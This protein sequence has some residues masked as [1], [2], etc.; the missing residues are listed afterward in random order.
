M[1]L[2][3]M[4]RVP[5]ASFLPRNGNPS[6]KKL[7]DLS[8]SNLK[9][10]PEG[11]ELLNIYLQLR[12]KAWKPWS[13]V[14]LP[15]QKIQSVFFDGYHWSLPWNIACTLTGKKTLNKMLLQSWL[16]LTRNLCH[17][18]VHLPQEFILGCCQISSDLSPTK[19]MWKNLCFSMV[20]PWKVILQ[21]L[22]TYSPASKIPLHPSRKGHRCAVL[23]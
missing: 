3:K 1:I 22:T 5:K 19:P 12:F 4:L 16:D 21:N 6:K 13:K 15:R 2:Q 23:R 11:V 7:I 10:D 18:T 20:K 9:S 14:V 8:G 17:D